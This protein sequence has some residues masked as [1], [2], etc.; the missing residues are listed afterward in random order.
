MT[1]S[2]SVSH[3]PPVPHPPLW[4]SQGQRANVVPAGPPP[5][6][7]LERV[8]E[9]IYTPVVNIVSPA[10]QAYAYTPKL[11]G[12]HEHVNAAATPGNRRPV[13]DLRSGLSEEQQVLKAQMREQLLRDLEEQVRE[14]KAA[15]AKSKAQAQAAERPHVA[16]YKLQASTE[17]PEQPRQEEWGEY[18]S[19]ASGTRELPR[20]QSKPS[21]LKSR[22]SKGRK[23]PSKL[24]IQIP[25]TPTSQASQRERR[26]SVASLQSPQSMQESIISLVEQQHYPQPHGSGGHRLDP[27]RSRQRRR[28]AARPR[29]GQSA[30]PGDPRRSEPE[31]EFE[32]RSSQ[33]LTAGS[34]KARSREGGMQPQLTKR[35]AGKKD[36]DMS[37]SIR[38]SASEEIMSAIKDLKEEQEQIRAQML[39]QTT[40]LERMQE[41]TRDAQRER[42]EARM[43]FS[44]MQAA[45]QALSTDLLV[46]QGSEGGDS[47]DRFVVDT[48]ML[49]AHTTDIP[50]NIN[51][52]QSL[53]VQPLLRHTSPIR[54]QRGATP[55]RTS[56][57]SL[58]GASSNSAGGKS[59]TGGKKPNLA[60]RPGEK[61]HRTVNK[62]SSAKKEGDSLSSFLE[63]RSNSKKQASTAQ[64]QNYRRGKSI[65]G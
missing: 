2:F 63:N 53:D 45:A 54:F 16:A 50:D 25:E 6:P 14:K 49:P 13:S 24:R 37:V 11:I 3:L 9:E 20:G 43:E 1:N 27:L 65:W 36:G 22:A 28:A 5:A 23:N 61:L 41:Q 44:R 42:D 15:Q 62:S 18:G 33:N 55:R 64:R 47:I 38:S 58:I 35:T 51:T 30:R 59:G 60:G 4:C 29:V 57:Q 52:A 10:P 34:G 32:A 8:R 56:M 26:T 31:S 7:R 19:E 46:A 12:H 40:L 39:M 21:A 48:H 17:V